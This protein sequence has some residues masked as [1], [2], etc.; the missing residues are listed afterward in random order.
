[1]AAKPTLIRRPV[2]QA[3][4]ALILGFDPDDYARRFAR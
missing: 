2:I 1:M 3:G 4:D